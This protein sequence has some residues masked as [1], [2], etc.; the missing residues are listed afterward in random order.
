[1]TQEGNDVSGSNGEKNSENNSNQNTRNSSKSIKEFTKT[2]SR[3]ARLPKKIGETNTYQFFPN[4]EKRRVVEKFDDKFAH[5]WI[6]RGQFDVIDPE[7]AEEG[8]KWL[9]APKTLTSDLVMNI[10]AGNLLLR[11]IRTQ[12]NPVKYS[13]VAIH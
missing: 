12:E 5:D 9:E 1:M 6:E 11:I 13:V 4:E 10:E 2:V 3:Y 8:E 7:H